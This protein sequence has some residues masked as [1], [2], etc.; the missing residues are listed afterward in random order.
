MNKKVVNLHEEQY[1][2]LTRRI[3]IENSKK[4][5]D[6]IKKMLKSELITPK[7][8]YNLITDNNTIPLKKIL[9]KPIEDR[10]GTGTYKTFG[11]IM[12]FD[13]NDGFPLL[14]TKK[15]FYK[16]AIEELFWIISGSTNI[17]HLAKLN[18]HIWDEWP[19]KNYA[20]QN[21]IEFNKE[22]QTKFIERIKTDHEFAMKWG[23]LGPVYGG[24]WRNFDGHDRFKTSIEDN[25]DNPRFNKLFNE[26][27]EEYNLKW[28]GN[29]GVDQ[30]SNSLDKIINNPNDRRNLIFAYNPREVDQQLLPSCLAV[31]QF[32]VKDN[33]LSTICYIRSQDMFLGAPFDLVSG[34]TLTHLM[35]KVTGLEVGEYI[36]I[37]GDTHIY[38]DHL[39]QVQEQLSREPKKCPKIRLLEN[40]KKGTPLEILESYHDKIEI[41][42]YD[43]YP[44]IKG[45]VSV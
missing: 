39:D 8:A 26:L 6:K 15:V 14:T 38:A 2:N 31:Y 30:L 16:R 18:N 12:R 3:I 19:F 27:V 43:P 44:V 41:V 28:E 5:Y 20:K 13:L 23:E 22:N 29:K 34:A 10:T 40:N 33:K 25:L 45:K 32:Y 42:G 21:N 24:Q 7:E 4:K 11:S 35:A 17:E 36:H 37:T 9:N 1:L